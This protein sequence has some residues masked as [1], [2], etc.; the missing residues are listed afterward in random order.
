[1]GK[2]PVVVNAD[3]REWET[4]PAHQVA[5]RGNVWWQTLISAGATESWA[6]TL[7]VGRLPPGAVLNEHR[8]EQAEVYFVLDGSGI[9]TI[10]G[11][12]RRVDPGTGVFIPGNAAHS[13]ECT[14]DADLRIAYTLAADAFADVNYVFSAR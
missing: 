6:L 13:L 5:E 3:D 1:M 10:D 9:V 11:S 7:G 4:W 14:G 8:H 2:E 12:A